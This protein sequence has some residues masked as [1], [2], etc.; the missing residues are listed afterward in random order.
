MKPWVSPNTSVSLLCQ[1]MGDTSPS[2]STTNCIAILLF[3]KYRRRYTFMALDKVKVLRKLFEK[4][5]ESFAKFFFGAHLRKETPDFHREIFKLY[6]SASRRIAIAAPRGHAK[7]TITDLVYLAWEIVNRKKNFVLMVAD[8]YSQ[9]ALQLDTLKAEFEGNDLLKAIYGNMTTKNWSD[10]EVVINETMVKAL[11]VGMKI[12]GLKYRQ[13]R[14]DLIIMDDL[15]NDEIVDSKDRRDKLE[16]W[17]SSALI[18]SMT[19]DGRLVMIGTILHYDDLMSKMVNPGTYTDFDKKIYRAINDWGALWPEHLNLAQLEKIKR[20]YTE[21]GYGYLF[22]QEY[23]NDP[24]SDENRKFKIEKVKYYSEDDLT[25]KQLRCYISIDR[26]Y[27]KEQTADATGIIIN[28]VDQDNNWY[29]RSERFKGT[30][31][32]LITKI[33]D[34]KSFFH[35][36]KIGIEQKAFKYT[37]EPSLKA[38]MQRRNSF[39]TVEEL[40]DGGTSKNRRIEGLLPRHEMGTIYLL[41][42]DTDLLD[43]MIR[44]P[45][46][47]HDDLVDALAYQLELAT[48]VAAKKERAAM[49]EVMQYDFYK[50]KVKGFF[51]GS[52]Y[53]RK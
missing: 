25:S 29:I 45:K 14:P 22:Y 1:C 33:F 46:G 51:S 15:E 17:V 27:S 47:V 53:L 10:G 11:G 26:A 37:I 36:I 38:E 24:V 30:E 23:Q 35:P 34:L 39:F 49:S 42:E 13:S 20:E 18:P 43:E 21:N 32:E 16:R 41:K 5:I 52:R 3:C 44:F 28:R 9:A 6:E 19:T 31:Q 8:T 4:D 7:S 48:S 2:E 40:K 50:K 12:R